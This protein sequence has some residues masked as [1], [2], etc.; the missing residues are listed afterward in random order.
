MP[1]L[2]PRVK[3]TPKNLN[4]LKPLIDL[5]MAAKAT[6]DPTLAELINIRASQLNGCARCLEMHTADARKNGETE[7]RIYMLDAWR[8]SPL[9]S[10]RERA[11]LGWTEAL[12]L[13]NDNDVPDDIYDAFKAHFTEEEQMNVTLL[14]GAI[15]AFNRFNVG[16]RTGHPVAAKAA[17]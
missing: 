9:Y 6:L 11:V 8:D 17:A 13:M 5:A 16:F 1:T 10:E 15:N 4:H 2:T 3:L 12:T 14:V 7:L